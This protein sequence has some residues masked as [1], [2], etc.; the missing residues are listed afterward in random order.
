MNRKRKLAI[1]SVLA[2]LLCAL[3]AIGTTPAPALANPSSSGVIV[4]TNN[5]PA[6]EAY[7]HRSDPAHA[8]KAWFDVYDAKCDAHPVYVEYS[9]NGGG[10]T[11][12]GNDGGCNTSQGY[13]LQTGYFAIV[14]RV[15][16]NNTAWF[17][18]PCSQ[19]WADHN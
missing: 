6:A 4:F 9:I 10:T 8:N 5:T 1:S 3:L 18:D 11:S 17:S 2:M 13:N 19:W 7:F 14:Y 15:C 16:V 12:K